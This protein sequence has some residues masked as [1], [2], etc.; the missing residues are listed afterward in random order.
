[1]PTRKTA[2]KTLTS[3]KPKRPTRAARADPTP[4]ASAQ[5]DNG[6]GQLGIDTQRPNAPANP[7]LKLKVVLT[8]EQNSKLRG[9]R[10]I[11]DHSLPASNG[12]GVD[13]APDDTQTR[14]VN[15]DPDY[16]V[17]LLAADFVDDM[18]NIRKAMENRVRSL[19]QVKGMG[20][21]AEHDFF[22]GQAEAIKE[23]EAVAIKKLERTMKAHPLGGFVTRT[24]GIGL[25]QGA[26]LLAATGNPYWNDLYDRPRRG[27]AELWAYCGL[28]VVDGHRPRRKKGVQANWNSTAKM[29]AFLVAES[30]I[31]SPTSPYRVVYDEA[32]AKAET[33]THTAQCQNSKRPPMKS[34]GCGTQANPEWGA[35]GSSWRAG[36]QHQYALGIVAKEILKDLWKEGKSLAGDS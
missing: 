13:Q 36:H 33:K 4:N 11:D 5:H 9:Q 12:A 8:E 23:I 16:L 29:R 24:S 3:G 32:R 17:L 25:K 21:T 22:L 30:C 7:F 14:V 27:P 2:S 18:E 35:P 20:G 28:H 34:N 19:D 10:T 1:M 31:K 26:R 15:S 6:G